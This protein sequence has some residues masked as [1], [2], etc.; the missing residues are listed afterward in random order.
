MGFQPSAFLQ[1]GVL[2]VVVLDRGPTRTIDV[3]CVLDQTDFGDVVGVEL[4]DLAR[5]IEGGAI[6]PAPC[7]GGLSWSYDAEID[8]LYVHVA[9]G[10]GQIQR[11]SIASVHIGPMGKVVG[12]SI[13]LPMEP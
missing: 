9:K 3:R 8:A 11:S 7:T 5:Q 10:P 13:A 4:L 12:L 2:H 1:D 6:D